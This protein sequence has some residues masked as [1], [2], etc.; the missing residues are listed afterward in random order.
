MKKFLL[1]GLALLASQGVRSAADDVRPGLLFVDGCAALDANPAR[2]VAAG[3]WVTFKPEGLPTWK[4]QAGFH[5]SLW[6]LSRF[7][8]GREQNGKRPKAER[9]GGKDRPLTEAMKADVR[10]FLDETRAKGGSLIVRLGYTWSEQ[11]GC[12][13]ADFD[14]LLGHVRDLSRIMADYDDVVVGVEAGLAGPWGEMHSSDYCK[15]EYMNRIL[16]TYCDNLPEPISILVRAPNY[17]CKLAGTNTVGTLARLPFTDAYLRRLGMYNDG[18]L[19]TWSDYGTWAGDFTRERGCAMLKTF[20][21]HPYGGEMAYIDKAWLA[22]NDKLFRLDAWNLVKEW[23]E[24][25]LSY[26]RNLGERGH[27]LAEHLSDALVF[28]AA[29]YRFDG[30]PQLD[31]YNGRSLNTFVRDHMG[32]RFVLR[33][34]RLP[35]TVRRGAGA[36]IALKLENTGFGRL[37]LPSVAELVFAQ[38]GTVRSVPVDCPLALP[39]ASTAK[40]LCVFKVPS[41]LPAGS[42]DVALRVRAPVKGEDVSDFPRRPIRFANAD[43]WNEVLR[44]NR[45]GRIEVK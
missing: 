18:Y 42:Y 32:Y 9:V 21:D 39:G 28:D 1:M 29:K 17:I 19:G 33:D 24:T 3:G 20:G 14:I 5:S 22:Q 6:E 38:G 43:G 36:K 2:G 37:L 35:R 11:Q 44:A 31:E 27:T 16:K 10:R 7:S 40:R 41:D 25:H 34:V 45:L 30:M 15:G 13:P 12:E 8:G 4:G 23:Y 26:L